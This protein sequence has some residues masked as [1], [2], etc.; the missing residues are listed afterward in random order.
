MND[1]NGK[2]IT[3]GATIAVLALVSAVSGNDTVVASLV[4][5]PPTHSND[6][7]RLHP[8]CVFVQDENCFIHLPQPGQSG[9]V[10]PTPVNY[11]DRVRFERDALAG[12]IKTL[13]AFIESPTFKDLPQDEKTRLLDQSVAMRDYLA[14]LNDRIEHFVPP[15]PTSVETASVFP[16]QREKEVSEEFARGQTHGFMGDREPDPV[17]D[18]YLAGHADGVKLRQKEEAGAGKPQSPD[19]TLGGGPA[20]EGSKPAE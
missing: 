20:P 4:G 10:A 14:C 12:N 9:A 8:G 3:P 16:P 15:A 11:Q 1:R 19:G 6:P 5:V 17:S 13:D 2:Q 7:L 18:D